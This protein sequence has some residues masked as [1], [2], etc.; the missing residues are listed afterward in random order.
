MKHLTSIALLATAATASPVE[1]LFNLVTSGASNSSHN[2]LYVTTQTTGPLNSNAVFG[3]AAT[4]STFYV[5]NGTV[6]YEASNGAPWEMALVQ[7]QC[8]KGPVEV[9]V[10]PTTGSEGFALASNGTLSVP[11]QKWGGWLGKSFAFLFGGFLWVV[12]MGSDG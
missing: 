11:G 5:N 9:S 7:S 6:H 2:G 3:T 12:K 8:V 10:S 1:K 4:A